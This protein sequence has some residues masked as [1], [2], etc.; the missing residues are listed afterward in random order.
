MFTYYGRWEDLDRWKWVIIDLGVILLILGY[1][2]DG[3]LGYRGAGGGGVVLTPL[4][5]YLL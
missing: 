1:R 4:S 3:V 2:G 5:T